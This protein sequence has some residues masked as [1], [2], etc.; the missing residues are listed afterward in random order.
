[1][2]TQGRQLRPARRLFSRSRTW[3]RQEAFSRSLFL[4]AFC[5]AVLVSG[6]GKSWV[7]T[8]RWNEDGTKRQTERIHSW[9]SCYNGAA[10]HTLAAGAVGA[11]NNFENSASRTCLYRNICLSQQAS[12]WVFYSPQLPKLGSFISRFSIEPKPD[13]PYAL[14]TVDI[15]MWDSLKRWAPSYVSGVIPEKALWADAEVAAFLAPKYGTNFGHAMGDFALPVYK[16][17]EA[18]EIKSRDVQLLAHVAPEDSYLGINFR[19]EAFSL[20]TSFTSLLWPGRQ[21][22]FTGSKIDERV[23]R[24][25]TPIPISARRD[26]VLCYRRVLAGSVPMGF[27]TEAGPSW[28]RFIRELVDRAGLSSYPKEPSSTIKVL[29]INKTGRR[30]I[31]NVEEVAALIRKHFTPNVEVL[32]SDRLETMNLLQQMKFA[33]EYDV[34]V[35]PCGGVSFL[36]A[37]MRED[38][39]T[40]IMSFRLKEGVI[41]SRME[42]NVWR[43]VSNRLVLHYPILSEEELREPEGHTGST[44]EHFYRRDRANVAVDVSRLKELVEYSFEYVRNR[45][46]E[47]SVK[48]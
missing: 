44:D 45:R 25:L 10:N 9:V 46:Q 24:Q 18:F 19:N 15:G 7:G 12:G 2:P 13:K 5:A 16:M 35:T 27:A 37:F 31:A 8:V 17:M 4:A 3:Q 36:T 14:P 48:Q 41:P 43:F 22:V 33:R 6:F 23:F 28:N 40:I 1:M 42:N 26:T 38:S 21:I 39:A 20:L 32:A 47:R 30:R 34:V 11:D 29:V